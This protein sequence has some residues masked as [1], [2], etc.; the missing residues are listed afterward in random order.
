MIT[1]FFLYNWISDEYA[2]ASNYLAKLDEKAKTTN[3]AL[4][5]LVKRPYAAVILNSA[6]G[7]LSGRV[8]PAA[9]A[10]HRS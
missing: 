10:D 8:C 6:S 5:D 4:D 7:Y 1:L 9:G 2:V 3:V